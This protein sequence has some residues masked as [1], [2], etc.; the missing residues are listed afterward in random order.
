MALT[1]QITVKVDGETILAK[2]GSVTFNP[3]GYER[4]EQYADNEFQGFTSKPVPSMCSGNLQDT[5][6]TDLVAMNSHENVSLVLELDSGAT[7]LMPRSSL[8]KPAEISGDAGEVAFEY[9]GAPA[10]KTG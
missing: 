10:I 9:R 7:Y 3:G 5:S 2:N 6:D 4:T 1:A 8:I